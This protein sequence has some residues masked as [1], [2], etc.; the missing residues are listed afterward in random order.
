MPRPKSF[1]RR[2]WIS[3]ALLSSARL[4]PAFSRT[5]LENDEKRLSDRIFGLAAA[6]FVAIEAALNTL[7]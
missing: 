1:P 5:L 4:I 7:V 3:Y 2:P 6:M